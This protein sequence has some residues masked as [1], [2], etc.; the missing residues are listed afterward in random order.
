MRE[1]NGTEWDW[2]RQGV[3]ADPTDAPDPMQTSTIL[4]ARLIELLDSKK[5]NELLKQ[6]VAELTLRVQ[7]MGSME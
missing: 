2:L 1:I 6:K 3:L 4:T 5:E 7:K